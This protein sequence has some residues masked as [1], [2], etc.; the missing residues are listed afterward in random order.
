[1]EGR[2]EVLVPTVPKMTAASAKIGFQHG[3]SKVTTGL[4]R[5]QS[6]PMSSSMISKQPPLNGAVAGA[7]SIESRHIPSAV[8]LPA[9]CSANAKMEVV[10]NGS[11]FTQ[12]GGTNMFFYPTI[13][14][15][16]DL[17]LRLSSLMSI[18]EMDQDLHLLAIW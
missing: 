5:N 4:P 17:P 11:N 16:T 13:H 10:V 6:N 14:A 15:T 8:S 12:N 7:S 2:R 18:Y 1:M 3:A 9:I